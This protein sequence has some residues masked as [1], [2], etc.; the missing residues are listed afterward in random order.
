MQRYGQSRM[1]AQSTQTDIAV[2]NPA[3]P[4][5]DPSKPRVILNI[6]LSLF[7]GTLLGVG[8]ASWLSCWIVVCVRGRTSPRDWTFQYWPK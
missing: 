2:L 4:P 7:L 6:L 8:W 5:L 1:E 3:A